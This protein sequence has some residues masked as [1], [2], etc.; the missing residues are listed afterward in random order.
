MNKTQI[1][2]TFFIIIAFIALII[3]VVSINLIYHPVEIKFSMTADNNTVSAIKEISKINQKNQGYC[4]DAL[5]RCLKLCR[6]FD[7]E[8]Q[9]PCYFGCIEMARSINNGSLNGGRLC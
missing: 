3:G 2:F 7:N 1:G 6:D 5:I 8:N 4:L 9:N